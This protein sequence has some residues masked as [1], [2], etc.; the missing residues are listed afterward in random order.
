M[1]SW[2]LDAKKDF[3]KNSTVLEL[4]LDQ[5]HQYPHKIAL[6]EEDGQKITY[7]ELNAASNKRAI[8]LQG[9]GVNKG[10]VVAVSLERSI[11]MIAILLAIA[12]LGA[13]YLA[14]DP[15]YP[16]ER[17]KYICEN[18]AVKLCID[19]SL[20]ISQIKENMDVINKSTKITDVFYIV[21]NCYDYYI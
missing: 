7:S 15:T 17:R 1:A 9:V 19:Q 13:V 18:A 6:I 21:Y 2:N 12:K 5:V 4:F 8:Y 3:P 20:E 10:D 14:I 11:E 16:L